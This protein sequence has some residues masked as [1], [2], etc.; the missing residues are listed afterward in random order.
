MLQKFKRGKLP[1]SM[2]ACRLLKPQPLPRRRSGTAFR[3]PATRFVV[4]GQHLRQHADLAFGGSG[5]GGFRQQAFRQRIV[6][7]GKARCIVE[8]KAII[9]GFIRRVSVFVKVP[10]LIPRLEKLGKG[11]PA[12]NASSVRY[13]AS[14]AFAVAE[15][16]RPGTST[17][18]PMWRS[19]SKW[20]IG[21]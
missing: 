11:R 2:I 17:D 6:G 15:N 8:A 18:L 1:P 7:L 19:S 9:S 14:Q 21:V 13:V 12:A 5:F 10:G 3:I 20:P 4:L 16:R